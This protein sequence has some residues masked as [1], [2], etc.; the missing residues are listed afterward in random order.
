MTVRLDE[1]ARRFGDS[2]A[3]EWKAFLLRPEVKERDPAKF[4]EYTRSWSR[5]AQTEPNAAFTTPWA[6]DSPPPA[7]SIP[8]HIAMKALEEVAPEATSAFHH[9]LLDAYFSE[10]RDISDW[11]V[12]GDLADDV[13]VE[14]GVML[15]RAQGGHEELAERVIAEHNEAIEAGITAVPTVVLDDVLPVPGAQEVETY[16]AWITKLRDRRL[17]KS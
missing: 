17:G 6:T 4:A 8:P 11:S 14:A 5:P 7:G 16:W 2:I 9:R 1:L 3:I 12:L 15:E 10:N 13:G